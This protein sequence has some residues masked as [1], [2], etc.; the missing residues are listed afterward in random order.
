MWP[1]K[2][3]AVR[4]RL[5]FITACVVDGNCHADLPATS[6]VIDES[7]LLDGL[8]WLLDWSL[9]LVWALSSDDNRASAIMSFGLHLTY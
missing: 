8:C 3:K 9:L 2:V 7:W 6:Q 5:I 4:Q 1:H